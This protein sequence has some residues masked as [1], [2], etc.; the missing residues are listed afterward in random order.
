MRRAAAAC[1]LAVLLLATGCGEGREADREDLRRVLRRTE[2]LA[3]SYHYV[4]RRTD[5]VFAV[6]G[7][8]E[9]DFRYRS[10]VSVDETRALE[11]LVRDDIVA[12]RV[13]HPSGAQLLGS[14]PAS[15]AAGSNGWMLDPVGAPPL[16]ARAQTQ[17]PPLGD[18]PVADARNVLLYVEQA[19][20]EAA[21]IVRYNPEALDYRASEDPFPEPDEKSGIVRY[22]FRL[23]PLP[24]RSELAG[25][26]VVPEARH[27]RKMSVY[28]KDGLVL[29]VLED[30]DVLS[31]LKDLAKIYSA[32]LP[33]TDELETLAAAA[34]GAVNSL[35]SAQGVEPIVVRTMSLQLRD[36][37]GDFSV[38]IPSD[39]ARGRIPVI[40]AP[41]GVDGR[42][43]SLPGPISVDPASIA[44][45]AGPPTIEGALGV[46]ATPTP[47]PTEPVSAGVVAGWLIA[48]PIGLIGAAL[49]VH[50]LRRARTLRV[51]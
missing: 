15:P 46:V 17:A 38:A 24:Q 9:D 48:V 42:P 12:A 39:A 2:N 49:L 47:A 28:I 34:I 29:Q 25:N 23:P 41:V 43:Q 36:L 10:T 35:R 44:P 37:G 13:L 11:Y 26:Q 18:D 20:E 5:R 50:R 32:E 22:D 21:T 7:A 3:R 1:G 51:P 8:V 14:A 33:D 19:M 40:H 16:V 30:V 6:D 4:D 31:R 45:G 27:F